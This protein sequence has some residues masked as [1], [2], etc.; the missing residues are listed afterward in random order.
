MGSMDHVAAIDSVEGRVVKIQAYGMPSLCRTVGEKMM[1][2]WRINA[3]QL[4]F[5]S[6]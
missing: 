1:A 6:G 4:A 5:S 3:L 2:L